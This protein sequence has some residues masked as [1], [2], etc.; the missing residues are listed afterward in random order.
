MTLLNVYYDILLTVN[1][2]GE[3]NILWY[4]SPGPASQLQHSAASVTAGSTDCFDCGFDHHEI[5]D[6][7]F[8]R[9]ITIHG[10]GK[11]KG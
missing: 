6:I 3:G 11:S 2:S 8:F 7:D 10:E 5:A 1:R 4:N 9:N